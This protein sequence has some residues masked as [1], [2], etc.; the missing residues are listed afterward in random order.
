[1][2]RILLAVML[3]ASI[4]FADSVLGKRTSV[5][6]DSETDIAVF[7]DEEHHLRHAGRIFMSMDTIT[8]ASG[9]SVALFLRAPVGDSLR[10]TLIEVTSTNL[11]QMGFYYNTPTD[12]IQG[13]GAGDTLYGYNV[14]LGDGTKA[15]DTTNIRFNRFTIKASGTPIWPAHFG[16]SGTPSGSGHFGGAVRS[17]GEIIQAAGVNALVR[18]RSGAASN[19]V[20]VR[21]TYYYIVE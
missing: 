5:S 18:I 11:I 3:L 1:M 7:M 14:F 16:S 6:Y 21:V 20:T 17:D 8:L 12:S 2:R 10:H 15:I 9:D 19:R 4:C 13:G